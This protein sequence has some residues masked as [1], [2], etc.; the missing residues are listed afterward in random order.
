MNNSATSRFRGWNAWL[1]VCMILIL[2]ACG[3]T[4]EWDEEVRLA[5]SQIIKV[6]RTQ[7]WGKTQPAGEG[8]GYGYKE[9]IIQFV[10]NGSSLPKWNGNAELPMLID[11]DEK[12][13][14][15]F[16]IT[17]LPICWRY[18]ELGRPSPPYLEY[19][20]KGGDWQ[21]SPWTKVAL[22]KSSNLMVFVDPNDKGMVFGWNK[23]WERNSKSPPQYRAV[24]DTH[25]NPG[26]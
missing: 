20:V 6:H 7:N 18:Y 8:V 14:D 19:R 15:Y 17:A 21:R 4:S 2:S 12:T 1:Y 16:L 10:S 13:G 11:V 24:Q 25:G 9:S 3:K 26:C 5:N 22:G 23:I